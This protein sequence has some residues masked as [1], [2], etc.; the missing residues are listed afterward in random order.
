MFLNFKYLFLAFLFAVS[1]AQSLPTPEGEDQIMTGHSVSGALSQ[2]QHSD[3][4][5]SSNPR[6][7]NGEAEEFS[8]EDYGL[9]HGE[10]YH[11]TPC[12]LKLVFYEGSS[13]G[14][15]HNAFHFKLH[16]FD[17]EKG[18]IDIGYF[19]GNVISGDCSAFRYGDGVYENYGKHIQI[20]QVHIDP[21]HQNRGVGQ[22]A[23]RMFFSIFK[24]SGFSYKV[25]V[26]DDNTR[27][28]HFFE[29]LGF[30]LIPEGAISNVK[31]MLRPS[32]GN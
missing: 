26:A 7:I 10:A 15:G 14:N 30:K 32:G 8:F 25:E 19:T 2:N 29:K 9:K 6:P 20:S 28:H 18:T 23:L 31:S 22:I 21:T 1:A 11:L 12:R 16:W 13:F 24:K 3:R 27:A 4:E 5:V 17:N